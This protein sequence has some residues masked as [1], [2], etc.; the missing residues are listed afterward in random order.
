MLK[1]FS[2][3]DLMCEQKRVL[4][5]SQYQIAYTNGMTF[6]G[7]PCTD[8]YWKGTNLMIFKFPAPLNDLV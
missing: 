5:I 6:F 8:F 7:G 1:Q 2:T 4:C 3:K